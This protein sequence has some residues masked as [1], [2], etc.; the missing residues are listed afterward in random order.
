M[1]KMEKLTLTFSAFR[2]MAAVASASAF[3]WFPARNARSGIRKESGR[4]DWGA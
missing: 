4:D 1:Y 3:A 2:A